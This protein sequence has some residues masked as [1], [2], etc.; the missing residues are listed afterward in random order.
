MK[1]SIALKEERASLITELEGLVNTASTEEREFTETE[2]T[3]QGDL[4]ESIYALDAKI[5]KAEKSEQILARNLA[6]AASKSD[7]VEMDN[8]AKQY[9]LQSAVEQFRMGGRLEGREAEMQ[10][11]AM[12][13]YREAGISPTGHIQ[14]PMGITY[15]GSGDVSAFAATTGTT[16]QP[17][18]PGLVPESIIEQAGAN[19]ITGVAGTVRL[20]ALPSDATLIKGEE[21]AM[22]PGSEMA[23]VDIAPVRMASRIDVSNQML[24]ASTSTFDSVVAAQ[25]RRHS[26]G[27]LDKQAWANF[28]AQGA[29]VKRSTTANAA[30]P[31]IDF[32]SANDLIAALG[33]AEALDQ[34]AAFFSSHG[35][36]A[37]ARSQQAV[38]NGGIPTL[39]ADGTIAGYKAYGHSQITAALLTDADVDTAAE[40][41]AAA[42]SVTSLSNEANALPFFLVNMNDVYCCYWGGADLI[43][44]NMSQAHAGVTRLIMNYYANCKVGHGGSAKYVAVV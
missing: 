5:T 38:T 1:Q 14:I 19:R 24:A 18:L 16:E 25:F 11:E 34:S 21:A 8:H 15:R 28:V 10:Q 32:A 44:D 39:Q 22:D 35:Q 3:R 31:A 36:L 40:V 13:E 23:A 30:I 4:N 27:L 17:V 33:T 2:E 43:V 26:G 29:L 6:G 12:K 42:G 41:Y 37:T 9:S 20:P 7:E